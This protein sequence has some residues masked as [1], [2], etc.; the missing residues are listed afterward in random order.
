[1]NSDDN[2]PLSVGER[3][4]ARKEAWQQTLS[5]QQALIDSRESGGW[6]VIKVRSGNTS[7]LIEGKK[8]GIEFI[9]PKSDAN[10]MESVIE[11]S[12]FTDYVMYRNRA[13]GSI[14]LVLEVLDLDTETAIS[15]AGEF[16]GVKTDKM[17]ERIF[18]LDEVTFRLSRLNKAVVAEFTFGHYDPL[19]PVDTNENG[20]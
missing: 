16:R 20:S 11:D 10:E 17:I 6:T 19:I 8:A 18:E 1:M 14:M 7:P 12:K 3:S 2:T 5:E 4:Q 15:I 9:V 13:G